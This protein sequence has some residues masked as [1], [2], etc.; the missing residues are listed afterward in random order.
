M[1]IIVTVDVEYDQ[2]EDPA[3][4]IAAI[5]N[6]ASSLITPMPGVSAVQVSD[7]AALTTVDPQDPTP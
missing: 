3:R 7:A 4:F 2:T 1:Q 5:Q 6:A